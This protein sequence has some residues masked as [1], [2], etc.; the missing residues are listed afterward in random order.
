MEELVENACS[1]L[2]SLSMEDE[3]IEIMRDENVI[4]MLVSAIK[5]HINASKVTDTYL[6]R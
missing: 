3:N 1:A 4:S 5:Q 2:W 6:Q